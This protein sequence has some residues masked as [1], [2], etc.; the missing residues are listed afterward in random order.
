MGEQAKLDLDDTWEPALAN[1]PTSG[2]LVTNHLN[3]MYML[4][5]GLVMPPAGF[6]DKYYADTLGTFPGWIP[7]FL[8]FP[9][10][11]AIE[12]AT[13]EADYLKPAIVRLDLSRLSGQM[14]AM[15]ADG[16]ECRDFRAGVSGAEGM[17]LVP[18]PLPTSWIEFI[19][20]R[21]TDEM[22]GCLSDCED[23]HNVALREYKPNSNKDKLFTKATSDPWPLSNGAVERRSVPL[24][25]PISAGGIMAMLQRFANLDD[26]AVQAYRISF[27]PDICASA[28][29][30]ED[31]PILA[32]LGLPCH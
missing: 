5:A 11:K 18:A 7:L 12:L 24:D 13:S 20:F 14:M 30:T 6:G 28:P 26:Q 19:A 21:T 8:D 31:H 29:M 17:I 2:L 9:S 1:V 15:S 23:H 27:N 32:G 16:V 4:A 10:K 22:R 3:L 25:Q